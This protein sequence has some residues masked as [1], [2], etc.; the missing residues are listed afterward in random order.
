MPPL[1]DALGPLAA[2]L[3]DRYRL[4][5]EVGRGGMATVYLAHDLRHDRPVALKVLRPELGAVLG[6]DRFNQEIRIAARLR[7]P[8]ILPVHD[9][10]EATGRL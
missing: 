8:H 7:H 3:A 10:G 9:S 5:R 4:E 6:P 1:P 2:A